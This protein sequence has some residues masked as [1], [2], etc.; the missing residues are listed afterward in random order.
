MFRALL[1]YGC[2]ALL[3][4]GPVFTLN[5][6][7]LNLLGL[8]N[9][10][11]TDIVSLHLW[12]WQLTGP[13]QTVELKLR[14]IVST[15]AL[16]GVFT[17]EIF[18]LYLP[19]R[20]R[21]QFRA[22]YFAE[23]QGEWQKKLGQD[24]RI[25][26]MFAH[27][28]WFFPFLRVFRWGWRSDNYSPPEGHFDANILLTEWQGVCGLAFR[29]RDAKFIDFRNS[30]TPVLRWW[31]RWPPWNRFHLWPSQLRKTAKLR[32]VVSIPIMKEKANGSWTA[33]GVINLDSISDSGADVLDKN[34]NKLIEYFV[35]SGKILAFLK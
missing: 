7:L 9:K 11:P 26:I 13:K 30:P 19:D 12:L 23:K 18:D 8:S 16:V 31:Q 10:R 15:I 34:R 32:Y 20:Q 14:L 5:W 3:V 29:A 22:E 33:V 6:S 4:L 25:N 17:A 1:R 21:R 27:R 35:K 28:L 2:Q 24:V